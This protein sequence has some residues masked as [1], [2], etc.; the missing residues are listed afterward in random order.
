[1][2]DSD[3][4]NRHPEAAKGEPREAQPLS[5]GLRC[6]LYRYTTHTV[7]ALDIDSYAE[8]ISQANRA[9]GL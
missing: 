8:R 1:M 5:E 3:D 9:A 7:P 2:A 6:A 4:I